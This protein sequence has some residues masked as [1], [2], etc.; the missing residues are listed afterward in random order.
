MHARVTAAPT[1]PR[2]RR[3]AHAAVPV[4]AIASGFTCHRSFGVLL[5]ELCSNENLFARRMR[6]DNIEEKETVNRLCMWRAV[7][8]AHLAAKMRP[9]GGF[10]GGGR[11]AA[12]VKKADERALYA[13]AIHL[14]SWCLQG[15]PADRPTVEQ[16]LAHPFTRSAA[17]GDAITPAALMEEGVLVELVLRKH[18]FISHMQSEGGGVA[19]TMF[20]LLGAS[21]A[22]AWL[23]MHE[24]DLTEAGMQRGVE[25]A[26]IFL[27]VLTTNV[28]HRPFVIKVKAPACCHCP[29]LSALLGCPRSM[30]LLPGRPATSP[31]LAPCGRLLHNAPRPGVHVGAAVGDAGHALTGGG[32]PLR[33]MGR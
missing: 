23:D 28:L 33:R 12:A 17:E 31:H 27:L 5:C 20:H 3:R 9:F 10:G 19:S 18:V 2:P 7:D 4:G 1:P 24:D 22:S 11:G 29:V 14:V 13:A 21:G 26:D 25:Q 30:L 6:D 15:D 32:Q 8:P 16:I